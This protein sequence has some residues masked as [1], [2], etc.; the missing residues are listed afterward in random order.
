[1]RYQDG[2]P[3]KTHYK[4]GFKKYES[5]V[6]HEGFVSKQVGKVLCAS[7]AVK[8]LAKPDSDVE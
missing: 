6:A 1:M 3:E 5:L 4:N 8:V 2:F 7:L